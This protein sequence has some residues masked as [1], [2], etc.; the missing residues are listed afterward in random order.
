[1]PHKNFVVVGKEPP[2]NRVK[3]HPVDEPR[4]DVD[5]IRR[6]I[7]GEFLYG[8]ET[9][10]GLLKRFVGTDGVIPSVLAAFRRRRE[11]STFFTTGEDIAFRLM[12]MLMLAGWKGRV[13]SMVHAS[14]G[15]NSLK[16]AKLL[17]GRLVGKYFTVSAMQRDILMRETGL[18][19]D[20]IEFLYSNVDTVFYDPALVPPSGAPDYVFACGQE[21][22][23]YATL[24]QAGGSG[25]WPVRIQASGFFVAEDDPNAV[26]PENVEI[27][28]TRLSFPDLRARYAG[29][30]FVVVPLRDVPYAAGV[31][32]LLEAMAMGK[33]VIVTD[34]AGIKDYTGL[35]SLVCVPPG[36]AQALAE[37][38]Q[39]L[40]DD[41]ESC[42]RMGVANREW[43]VA[44]ARVELYADRIASCIL[45]Q[46]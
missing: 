23:D 46:A 17:G 10:S 31:T 1:M 5:L 45:N 19:A 16:M 30:R 36:N 9:K 40:W 29:A 34:T 39:R 37:A 35:D 3:E 4:Y 15:G 44:N 24:A 18:G 12:P 43:V 13:F 42:R 28:R 41:P 7:M 22:R 14:Q 25:S 11:A 6:R 26:L 32:G 38:I 8:A 27:N 2:P 20:Q 21:N 33:A